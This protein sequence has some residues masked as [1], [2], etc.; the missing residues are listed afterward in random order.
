MLIAIA[1]AYY[2]ITRCEELE[3]MHK[4]RHDDYI[5]A[6]LCFIMLLLFAAD[7]WC[8][9]VATT[10]LGCPPKIGPAEM[11]VPG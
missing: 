6:I 11:G 7:A 2:C 9:T 4:Q 8:Q 1:Y 3:M 5:I 10:T